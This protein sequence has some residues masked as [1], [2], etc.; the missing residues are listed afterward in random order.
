MLALYYHSPITKVFLLTFRYFPRLRL[1]LLAVS[2]L[3]LVSKVVQNKGASCHCWACNA[4]AVSGG[5][6]S[7]NELASLLLGSTQDL[8]SPNDNGWA[9]S[10]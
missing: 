10:A 6:I 2:L 1:Q 4:L 7:V 5:G 8:G 9:G 3:Y